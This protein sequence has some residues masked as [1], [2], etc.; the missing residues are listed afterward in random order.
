M[1]VILS[2]IPSESKRPKTI[3]AG[4]LM[5][6]RTDFEVDTQAIDFPDLATVMLGLLHP[7]SAVCGM[8]KPAALDFILAHEK[9]DRKLYA[10]YLGQVNITKETHLFV[11]LR[12]MEVLTKQAILYAGGGITKDSVPE[13]EWIETEMKC[14]TIA[15]ALYT[16]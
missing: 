5:H 11:N 7:T 10:G 12:C 1:P 13:R 15:Q 4:N 2:S 3:V 8:P 14:K 6:L 9:H 16:P